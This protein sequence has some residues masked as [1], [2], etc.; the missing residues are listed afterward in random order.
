MNFAQV[1][2]FEVEHLS[3]AG[4]TLAVFSGVLQC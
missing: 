1:G 3:Q 2:N 4:R